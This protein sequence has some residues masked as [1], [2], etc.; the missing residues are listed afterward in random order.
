MRTSLMRGTVPL[1]AALITLLAANALP[2]RAAAVTAASPSPSPTASPKL[3][4]AMV[5]AA[6]RHPQMLRNTSRA[7]TLIS[8]G[9]LERTGAQ[10]VADALRYTA[11]VVVQQYGVPGSLT[12]VALRGGSSAQTLV[13]IDGRPANEADTG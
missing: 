12:T 7:A 1:C 11:G 4:D 10:S 9:D 13:L 5:I 2:G 6:Q 8:R 3:L